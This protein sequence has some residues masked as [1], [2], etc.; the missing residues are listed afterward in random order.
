[1]VKRE[2][3]AN[4]LESGHFLQPGDRVRHGSNRLGDMLVEVTVP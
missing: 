2:F 4:E 1:M 3:L